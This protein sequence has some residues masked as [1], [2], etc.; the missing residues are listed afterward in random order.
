MTVLPVEIINRIMRYVSHPIADMFVQCVKRYKNISMVKLRDGRILPLHR[1]NQKKEEQYKWYTHY[2]R[3]IIKHT[4]LRHYD[5]LD[6]TYT[7]ANRE[8]IQA[9]LLNTLP[10]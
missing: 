10:K 6:V 8:H 1:I 2:E 4:I 9:I 5:H 7:H 3:K